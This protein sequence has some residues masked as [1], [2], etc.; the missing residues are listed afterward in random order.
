MNAKLLFAIL[1][2]CAAPIFAAAK[3]PIEIARE[4]DACKG[5][6]IVSAERLDNRRIEVTCGT[7]LA[8]GDI[9]LPAEEVGEATNLIGLLAPILGAGAAGVALAA[10]AGSTSATSATSGTN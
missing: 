1:A 3:S 6:E 9:V 5:S 7:P 8:G 4:Q 2:L 10:G